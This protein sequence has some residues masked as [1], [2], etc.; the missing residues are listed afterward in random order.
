LF[1]WEE[2]EKNSRYKFIDIYKQVLE[3]PSNYLSI[4]IK[5]IAELCYRMG[6]LKEAALLMEYYL[7]LPDPHMG[8]IRIDI[9]HLKNLDFL[10]KIYN[11]MGNFS[12][13]FIIQKEIEKH[14]LSI[15]RQ[16]VHTKFFITSTYCPYC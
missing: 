3:T 4:H 1:F 6:Y 12:K 5:T 13:A 7:K 2:I 8:C 11:D 14:S 9:P 16:R 15:G 10:S